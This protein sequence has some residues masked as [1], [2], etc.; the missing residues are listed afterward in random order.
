M[1]LAFELSTALGLCPPAD[2]ARVRAH[3]AKVGLPT[4]PRGLGQ[5]RFDAARLVDLMRQD[6]KAQAG[7]LTFILAHGIGQAFISNDVGA[8]EVTAVLQNALRA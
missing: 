1:A 6:K 8:A 5:R 7:K 2:T 3:L 4:S